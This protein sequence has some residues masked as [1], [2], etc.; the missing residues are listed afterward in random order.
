MAYVT[1][2]RDMTKVKSKLILNLTTRQLIC[3]GA[4]AIMGIP[5][6]LLSMG[7]FGNQTAMLLLLIVAMP[8]FFIA[9]YE[10]DGIPAEKMMIHI[11]RTKYF[12]PPIRPYKTKNFYL[13]IEKEGIK[14]A[15]KKKRK[16][17]Q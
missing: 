17:K 15:G 3:F 7:T 12:F 8:W 11:L 5:T 13:Y 16:R 9:L 6:Y 10:K 4:A 2:P 14:Y 1:V